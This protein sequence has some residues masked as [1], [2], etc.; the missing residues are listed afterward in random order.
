MD[1]GLKCVNK[2]STPSCYYMH[3]GLTK[4]LPK[5]DKKEPN[6]G[7]FNSNATLK[8]KIL[9]PFLNMKNT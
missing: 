1:F 9:D 4:G 3:N 8:P 5:G 2:S 6:K 7:D